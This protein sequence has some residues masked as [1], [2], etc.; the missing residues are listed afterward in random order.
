MKVIG[1]L[2][3]ASYTQ[4]AIAAFL[5]RNN[6]DISVET[7]RIGGGYGAKITRNVLPYLGVAFAADQLNVP[8]KMHMSL[9][10]NMDMIGK[11]HPFIA[12]YKVGVNSAGKLQAIKVTLYSDGGYSYDTSNGVISAALYA[13]DNVYYCPNTYYEGYLAKTNLPP[14]TSYVEVTLIL[15]YD[16]NL[17]GNV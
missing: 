10:T 15:T 5:G 16:L 2:Q 13:I 9:H 8:I 6:S 4:Q 11:R 17:N 14:N 1:S 12:N 3:W 7:M